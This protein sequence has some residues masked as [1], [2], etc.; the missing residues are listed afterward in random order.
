MLGLAATTQRYAHLDSDP[1]R[2]A[3]N[4]IGGQIAAAPGAG[5]PSAPARNMPT[6]PNTL[7]AEAGH[8]PS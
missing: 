3:A 5:S 6:L 8:K 1:L 7:A 4:E 2:R